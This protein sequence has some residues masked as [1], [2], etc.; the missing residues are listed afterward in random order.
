MPTGA[1][2]GTVRTG[3]TGMTGLRPPQARQTWWARALQWWNSLNQ[4][5]KMIAGGIAVFLI[6]A[7]PLAIRVQKATAY[8]NLYENALSQ[9][10][11][12]DV[13][14]ALAQIGIP[15]N[16]T[17]DNHITVP[18]SRRVEALSDL[19]KEGIPR[20][21]FN[22]GPTTSTTQTHEEFT[23]QQRLSLERDITMVLREFNEI[24][25]ANVKLVIPSENATFFADEK[26]QAKAA[27]VLRLKPG[28]DKLPL[29]KARAIVNLVA[30]SVPMLSPDN[31]ELSDTQ[32][33]LLSQQIKKADDGSMPDNMLA[34]KKNL[35]GQFE[36]QIRQILD[37]ALGPDKYALA[38]NVDLN[39]NKSQSIV[40]TNGSELNPKGDV[41]EQRQI[42]TESYAKSP[43]ASSQGARAI[44][45][46]NDATVTNGS[47]SKNGNYQRSHILEKHRINATETRT[48]VTPGQL[49]RVTASVLTEE[50]LSDENKNT[51]RAAVQN[52]IGFNPDRA[53]SISFGTLPFHRDELAQMGQAMNTPLFVRHPA[54]YAAAANAAMRV[55]LAAMIF[56]ALGVGF[57]FF[58]QQKAVAEKTQLTLAATP[59]TTVSDISDLLNEKTGK[60]TPAGTTQASN[61]RLEELVKQ[62]PTK[63]AE[64]LK[65]TW[66]AEK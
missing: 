15:Y 55:L 52:A 50:A 28:V 54:S 63:V 38:V 40:Q 46:A 60:A 32:G 24:S 44:A 21:P 7:L 65:T 36:S 49:N 17:I 35:Q 31:V 23:E 37:K 62:K 8:T 9:D 12:Q 20:H 42:D 13:S 47:S 22:Q 34:Q 66:L 6:L 3:M 43:G 51:L 30:S 61:Q 48:D 33:R 57:Y 27:V 25:D 53:D 18:P 39:W 11:V 56:G 2:T 19:L 16:K 14:M 4:K 58:R 45:Y 41:I 26:P 64:L 1:P 59:A 29:D 10:D 5:Q